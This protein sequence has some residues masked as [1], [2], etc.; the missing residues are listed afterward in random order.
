MWFRDRVGRC[1]GIQSVCDKIASDHHTIYLSHVCKLDSHLLRSISNLANGHHITPFSLTLQIFTS[2]EL[3][4]KFYSEVRS[5][6]ICEHIIYKYG[7]ISCVSP[8]LI[9]E[10]VL[11]TRWCFTGSCAC[12]M[13][14][15][16][17][18]ARDSP[19]F[20]LNEFVKAATASE[21]SLRI[22]TSVETFLESHTTARCQPV[23]HL[24]Y[25]TVGAYIQFTAA[26]ASRRQ[27][28]ATKHGRT[29]YHKKHGQCWSL[30]GRLVMDR[31]L[32][33]RG[34]YQYNL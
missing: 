27:P 14:R 12:N 24:L 11:I 29:A 30:L 21:M 8:I 26:M 17:V 4:I 7:I 18:E 19:F 22:K 1:N 10:W 3:R 20:M 34:L 2:I 15:T 5:I 25:W 33:T 13:L 9:W 16:I 6:S 23:N 31:R 32:M 28:Y